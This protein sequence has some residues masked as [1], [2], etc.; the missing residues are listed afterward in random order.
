MAASGERRSC[1]LPALLC[2]ENDQVS[3]FDNF[4]VPSSMPITLA[5]SW[6]IKSRL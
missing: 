1:D 6:L 4:G 5:T 2:P 3:D